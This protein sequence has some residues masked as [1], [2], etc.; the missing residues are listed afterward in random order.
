MG[1]RIWWL[2]LGLQVK[3]QQH[4][5]VREESVMGDFMCQIDQT[6]GYPDIQPNITLSVS[7]RVFLNVFTIQVSRD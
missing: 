5:G 1:T 3:D 4:L 6:T 2:G 7:V